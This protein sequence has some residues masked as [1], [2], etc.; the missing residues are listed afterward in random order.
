MTKYF[1]IFAVGLASFICT[2]PTGA[3]VNSGGAN[4]AVGS[5]NTDQAQNPKSRFNPD[6]R[7]MIFFGIRQ[8]ATSVT[9]P[10]SDFDV[11][12]GTQVQSSVELY[13]LPDAATAVVPEAK[14]YKFTMINNTVILVDPVSMQVVDTI[15]Q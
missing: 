4:E 7:S 14:R 5:I 2:N 15:R 9:R 11:F 1:R 13:P 6:Q 12:V 3:Q 10:P 8:S